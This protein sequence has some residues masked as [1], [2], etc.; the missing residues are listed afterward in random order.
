MSC[1]LLVYH[2]TLGLRKVTYMFYFLGVLLG[3]AISIMVAFNGALSQYVDPMVAIFII[4]FI[5]LII[6]SALIALIERK[7]PSFKHPVYLYLGGVIGVSVVGLTNVAFV[8]LG[9]AVAVATSMLG[10]MIASL[11]I[12]WFGLFNRPV[13]KVSG[14]K[15]IGY[16]IVLIGIV[17]MGW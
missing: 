4:H 3:S 15:W 17:M 11:F 9:G 2:V 8:Y 14:K 5:G 1:F 10:Q 13:Y 6:V 12:D 16:G 7:P